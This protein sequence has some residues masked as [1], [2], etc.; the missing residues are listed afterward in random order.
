MKMTEV[1][2][3]IDPKELFNILFP[4]EAKVILLRYGMM[5]DKV[6]SK[7]EIGQIIDCSKERINQILIRAK[8]KLKKTSDCKIKNGTQA[9][10]IKA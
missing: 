10:L 3:L 6:H 4:T 7:A 8:S 2:P 9:N 1:L 5:D